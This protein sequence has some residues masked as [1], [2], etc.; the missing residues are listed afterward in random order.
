[1]VAS[2][3][4]TLVRR[5]TPSPAGCSLCVARASS[6]V[7]ARRALPQISRR[8]AAWVGGG[9]A[10]RLRRP[11]AEAFSA[12]AEQRAARS[13][14]RARELSGLALEE[15]LAGPLATS[16]R[17]SAAAPRKASP[18]SLSLSQSKPSLSLSQSLPAAARAGA[19][20]AYECRPLR[21][22]TISQ[23]DK[24]THAALGG[25]ETELDARSAAH[26]DLR[27]LARARRGPL[28]SASLSLSHSRASFGAPGVGDCGA[29]RG[30]LDSARSLRF[31]A[32]PRH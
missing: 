18:L 29:L 8:A 2:S 28:E 26:A 22:G 15:L 24:H 12:A 14:Q 7:R 31:G 5:K 25:N 10:R 11:A 6:F 21:D 1:M 9:T 4:R 23:P 17:G 19:R 16:E 27:R 13:A 30:D 3:R 32:A 20:R